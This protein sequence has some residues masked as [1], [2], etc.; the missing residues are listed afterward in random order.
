[1]EFE[2]VLERHK[3]T[4]TESVDALHTFL[5]DLHDETTSV[6]QAQ[7]DP[8]GGVDAFASDM[9]TA[10][11]DFLPSSSAPEVTQ[12]IESI[13]LLGVSVFR[14]LTSSAAIVTSGSL[15]L[16]IQKTQTSYPEFYVSFHN[17]NE[18]SQI[19]I[20][21]GYSTEGNVSGIIA[22]SIGDTWETNMTRPVR[23]YPASSITMAYLVDQDGDDVHVSSDDGFVVMA[24]T[25]PRSQWQLYECMQMDTETG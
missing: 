19:I 22:Y 10:I 7:V 13:Q 5:T 8:Y 20:P 3:R 18:A 15:T 12:L 25:Q 2:R 14:L 9:L 24:Q 4:V 6:M 21:E 1:M 16:I 11:A 17:S 23:S